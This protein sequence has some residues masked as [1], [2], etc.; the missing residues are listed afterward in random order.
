MQYNNSYLLSLFL[1]LSIS[2]T[3]S[4]NSILMGFIGLAI[5]LSAAAQFN[6]IREPSGFSPDNQQ[7][8]PPSH[9]HTHI[10]VHLRI[11]TCIKKK[12]IQF[13]LNNSGTEMKQPTEATSFSHFTDTCCVCVCM[14]VCA[15]CGSFKTISHISI[16]SDFLKL[17]KVNFIVLNCADTSMQSF[18][19]S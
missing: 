5:H 17:Q 6:Y 4:C 9:M 14:C 7:H 10:H 11:Y 2:H 3:L 13:L 19:K 18:S 15:L 16:I 8:S 1:L 12:K